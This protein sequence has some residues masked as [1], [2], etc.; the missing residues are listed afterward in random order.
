M[1][2]SM[3]RDTSFAAYFNEVAP[4][5]GARQIRILEVFERGGEFTN[6]EI[7]AELEWSINRVTPRVFELRRV[8][9]LEEAGRRECRIT[10]R[11]V[12]VWR[13]KDAPAVKPSAISP[14]FY[15]FES[16]S[17]RGETHRVS[18]R[19]TKIQCSCKGF[20]YRGICRHTKEIIL[21][22]QQQSMASLF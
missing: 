15:Q 16:R 14:T 21:K 17:E 3:I 11:T 5:L 1:G 4:T 2:S 20:F 19:G 10:H 9:I 12:I 18:E 8:G 13:A 22:E 7:A 6:S